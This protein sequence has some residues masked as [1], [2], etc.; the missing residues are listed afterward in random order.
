M[1]IRWRVL[2]AFWIGLYASAP[3]VH[4]QSDNA[5][6][7]GTI[8]DSSG[9]VVPAATVTITNEATGEIRTGT[10]NAAGFYT[11]TNL[12]PGSYTVHIEAKGFQT[13]IQTHNQLQ[14]SIG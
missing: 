13:F 7:S 14:P 11:I 3:L 1:S 4:A 9:A 12:P 2:L 5:S 8:T 6:I 10:S